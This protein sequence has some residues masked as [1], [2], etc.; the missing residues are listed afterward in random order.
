[1]SRYP[2]YK[3]SDFDASTVAHLALAEKKH[4]RWSVHY[5]SSSPLVQGLALTSNRW[6]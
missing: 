5:S 1:M 6:S 4:G 2:N 3:D